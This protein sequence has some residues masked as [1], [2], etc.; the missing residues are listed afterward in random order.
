MDYLKEDEMGNFVK[1]LPR[2]S[3]RRGKNLGDLIVNAKA[4]EQ[5]GGSGPCGKGCK[6]CKHM[7]VTDTVKD[8][9]GKE[10]TLERKMD[11]KTVGAIYGM[12][13]RKC[14]KVVYVGK[15]QNRVMDRFIGHRADLRGEDESKPAYH[16][17]RDGHKEEDMEVVGLEHVPGEDDVFRIARERWW[18]NRMGTFQEENKKR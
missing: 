9:E 13:C 11:C 7:R 3:L 16:F 10:M 15:T 6:L 4:R 14:K 2:L 18:M 1:E 12:Y 8:K 5:E 17:K